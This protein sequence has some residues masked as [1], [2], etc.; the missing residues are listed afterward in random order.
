MTVVACVLPP[1][2]TAQ[3]A[4]AQ[5]ATG[6]V[7]EDTNKNRKL[8]A[9]ETGLAGVR[10][11]NGKQITKTDKDGRYEL[12]VDDDTVIFVIK[13]RGYRSPLSKNML[14]RFYSVHKP[15]GSPKLNFPGVKPTGPLPAS[16]DFPMYAQEEPKQFE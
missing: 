7:F 10:V 9:G 2:P 12:P 13:P 5:T 1:S 8:D 11:S 6:R 15:N 16:V 4:K 3:E 14:P